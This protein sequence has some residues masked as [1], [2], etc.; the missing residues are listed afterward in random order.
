MYDVFFISY[1]ESNREENW[2]QVLKF[3]PNAIHIEGVDG[4]ANAHMLC[5]DICKTERFWTVDGDN[6]LLKELSINEE[7]EEDL[8]FF[9]AID[10]IDG[11]VSTIGGVKLW[12]KNSIINKDMSKGDFCKY[13][14]KSYKVIHET[15]SIHQYANTPEEAWRHTFRHIVKSL[16]GIITK[17][18][19]D[20]NL[21]RAE[22]HRHLNPHS[23][24]GYLDALEYAK[25]C[26]SDFDKIN[27]INDFSWLK[28]KSAKK[29]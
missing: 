25:E 23:Y 1:D 6:F 26:N 29:V 11:Y 27:L 3:H 7:C 24:R 10:P 14:T 16:T 20:S 12:K 19:L 9:N 2:K 21:A 28:L 13:A 17:E 4:I 18:V 8:L 15:M 22:E 5:N